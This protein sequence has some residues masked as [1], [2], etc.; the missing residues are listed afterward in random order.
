[1]FL[2]G[3]GSAW[4]VLARSDVTQHVPG[5]NFLPNA[6]VKASF[7]VAVAASGLTNMLNRNGTG[8]GT[9]GAED[10]WVDFE[11]GHIANIGRMMYCENGFGGAHASFK[12][13]HQG[14]NVFVREFN[15]PTAPVPE[16][17]NWALL[18]AGGAA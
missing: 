6:T 4:G 18:L 16:P 1:M 14:V 17:G 9:G 3:D 11:G 8:T 13:A 5:D 10:L 2:T 12:R 7:G 15:V